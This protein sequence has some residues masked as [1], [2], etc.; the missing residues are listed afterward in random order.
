[1]LRIVDFVRFQVF[2]L[3][4]HII[5]LCIRESL[6]SRVEMLSRALLHRAKAFSPITVFRCTPS[7][8]HAL[9]FT[10]T[11]PLLRHG[12]TNIPKGDERRHAW[13]TSNKLEDENHL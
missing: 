6:D 2:E 13:Y 1:M 3:N 12:S 5:D 9:R 10:L 8:S 7:V 4:Y 11:R